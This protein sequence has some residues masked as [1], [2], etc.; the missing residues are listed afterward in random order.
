MKKFLV[1]TA[2][3]ISSLQQVAACGYS[4]YGEDVRYCLFLPSYF[5]YQDFAAFNYNANLYSDSSAS[6]FGYESN[7]AD[8]HQFLGKKVP[9]DA[10]NTFMYDAKLTDIHPDSPNAFINYL[11]QTKAT[12]VLEYLTMAKK[13]EVINAAELYDAWERN[14]AEIQVN[15]DAF[16]KRLLQHYKV[17]KNIFLK[18]KYA[19]LAIRVAYYA[20]EYN[21]IH[22]L[23]ETEFKNGKKD[24]LYYWSLYFDCF[25]KDNAAVAIASVMANSA[26]KKGQLI[27]IS[28]R[29][30]I[31]KKH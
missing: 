15:R 18:R 28:V 14:D 12:A 4:P 1:F 3:L 7:I 13:S 5:D 9:I 10:I 23:F 31:C 6:T 24:Y 8:W 11:Y 26:E 21:Q 29:N 20:K 22:S 30:L 25:G 27:T 19:F 2:L 17:E 16:L